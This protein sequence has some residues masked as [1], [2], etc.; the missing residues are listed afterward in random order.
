MDIIWFS[1]KLTLRCWYPSLL[2]Q[3]FQSTNMHLKLFISGTSSIE[4]GES[5][6]DMS[7]EKQIRRQT[8][9]PFLSLFRM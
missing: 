5:L 2:L 1:F 9:F 3:I 4:I 7:T 8:S 6:S